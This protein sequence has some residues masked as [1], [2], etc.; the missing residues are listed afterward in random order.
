MTSDS[1]PPSNSPKCTDSIQR[2]TVITEKMPTPERVRLLI[3]TWDSLAPN[4][5]KLFLQ[6]P[7]NEFAAGIV[8]SLF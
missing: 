2:P 7:G 4:E 3:S 1:A 6:Q 5:R 8:D